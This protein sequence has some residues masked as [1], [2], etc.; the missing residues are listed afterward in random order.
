MARLTLDNLVIA[1]E[2][3]ASA[4]PGPSPPIPL[5]HLARSRTAGSPTTPWPTS[6]SSSGVTP[7]RSRHRQLLRD[8]QAAAGR[9]YVINVCTDIACSLVGGD[10]LLEHA[11][12]TLGG[13]RRRH[14][15]RR[16]VHLEGV[17]CIAACT[18]APCPGELP[19]L[20][21]GHPR[22]LRPARRRPPQRSPQGP[23]IPPRGTRPASA[24]PS[25]PTRAAGAIVPEA[26]RP[27][28]A[29]AAAAATRGGGAASDAPQ[30]P[31]RPRGAG[32]VR[33]VPQ[34]RHPP[35]G[36]STTPT[37]RPLPATGGMATR[38]PPLR[39]ARRPGGGRRG[40]GR[41][42][43]SVVVA[44][45]SPAGVKWGF[46]PPGVARYLVVNGDESE[47]GTYKDRIPCWSAI[48]TSSSRA[49]S[50]PATPS[51][52]PRRSSTSGRD[53]PRPGA[54][55]RRPQR[56]LRRRLVGKNILG[57]DY[58]VDVVLHW[59][60]GAYIV[61][62]ETAPHREPRGQPGM[63]PPQ[64]AVLPG[65]PGP[66][67]EPTI[68]NNVETLSNLPWIINNGAE[69]FSSFGTETSRAPACYCGV[70]ATST[71]PAC[72][73]SSSAPPRTAT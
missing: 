70:R 24:S 5:L 23:E 26:S 27:W 48:P 40:Q 1:R 7:P 8:V 71:T 65:G 73:R 9:R 41:H 10:E 30:T 3:I 25:P 49:C 32:T 63:P 38:P 37:P 50:S 15:R 2:I 31:G 66:L 28:L 58:S 51:A 36:T 16:R 60:A 61:G 18:E 47:P 22:G 34:G 54:H 68:V 13:P 55:R 19:L 53:G 20:A 46:C 44:P 45:A 43:C 56:G 33:E 12:E 69:A 72:S 42:R 11:E 4:T 6:P 62:E 35:A 52:A 17:Q 67:P 29:S 39:L 21:Q 64:A 57:T 59:G 14:H